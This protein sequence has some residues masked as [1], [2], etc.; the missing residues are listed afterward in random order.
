MRTVARTNTYIYI[1]TVGW[2][3]C[4]FCYLCVGAWGWWWWWWWWNSGACRFACTGCE[5][6]VL[7]AFLPARTLAGGSSC[8][9]RNPVTGDGVDVTPVRR[10]AR[11]CR[12]NVYPLFFCFFSILYSPP[13]LPPPFF[14]L[15]FKTIDMSDRVF[16][17]LSSFTYK[18]HIYIYIYFVIAFTRPQ[19]GSFHSHV[20]EKPRDIV[21][22]VSRD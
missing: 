20:L 22:E 6:V 10:S 13:P 21:W 19:I 9:T 3:W 11:R 5:T 14:L 1:H 17:P 7:C 4:G 18:Y 16:H 15:L 8:L 2:R 12:G